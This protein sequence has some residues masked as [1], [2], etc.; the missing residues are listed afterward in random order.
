M[1]AKKAVQKKS[2]GTPTSKSGKKGV[3]TS[4]KSSL[5][6]V[7]LNETLP[8]LSGSLSMARS[9]W[10]ALYGSLSMDRS[11]WIALYGSLA[12]SELR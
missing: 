11:L 7:K 4:G 5:N 8:K 2:V 1:V 9:L 10:I 6:R 3:S 12:G